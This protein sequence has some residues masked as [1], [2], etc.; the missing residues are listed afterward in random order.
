MCCTMEIISEFVWYN[1]N[2]IHIF[3]VQW[4]SHICVL[5]KEIYFKSRILRNCPQ[6]QAK[7]LL[8]GI[9]EEIQY[10]C[11]RIL[12]EFVRYDGN[13]IYTCVVQ[14]K[15][16]TNLCATTEILHTVVWYNENIIHKSVWYNGNLI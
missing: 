9:F 6:A 5:Y 14:W 15:S 1:E 3:V 13:P 4:K 2:P 12:Y 11:A 10:K 16:Y 8:R 7:P